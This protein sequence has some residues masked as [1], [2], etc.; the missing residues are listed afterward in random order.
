MRK[1][2]S[3]EQEK[4]RKKRQRVAVEVRR[5]QEVPDEE[6]LNTRHVKGP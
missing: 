4:A 5:G 3:E 6:N 1:K 2:D